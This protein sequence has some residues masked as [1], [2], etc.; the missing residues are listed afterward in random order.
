MNSFL[1]A[2]PRLHSKQRD[3]E[4]FVRP[5][6]EYANS[7]RTPE[8]KVMLKLWR[9]L[10][11]EISHFIKKNYHLGLPTLKYRRLLIE[12]IKIIKH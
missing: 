10:K 2:R 9:R 5:H 12:V 8:K 11:E 6:L 3:N 1:I 7:V 4:S